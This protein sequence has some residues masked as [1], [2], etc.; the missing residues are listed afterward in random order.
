MTRRIEHTLIR[1]DAARRRQIFQGGAVDRTA[2]CAHGC[3]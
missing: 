3:S 2:G 1:Q